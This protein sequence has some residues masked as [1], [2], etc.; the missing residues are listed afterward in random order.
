M[1]QI[2]ETK[3]QSLAGETYPFRIREVVFLLEAFLG[4][5]TVAEALVEHFVKGFEPL[6]WGKTSFEQDHENWNFRR[7]ALAFGWLRLRMPEERWSQLVKPLAKGNPKLPRYSATLAL[8]ADD[9]LPASDEDY[10]RDRSLQRRDP[11]PFRTLLERWPKVWDDAQVV[12]VLGSDFLKQCDVT[13]LRLSPKWQQERNLVELG[14]IRAPG[15]LRVIEALLAQS[16]R[17][18]R[19]QAVAGDSP[20]LG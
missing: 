16:L 7:T 4:T 3:F 12:Y 15:T 2:F 17:G 1:K 6:A 11:A 8:F 20:G 10:G 14:A 18:G 19:R 13:G 5:E 9:R